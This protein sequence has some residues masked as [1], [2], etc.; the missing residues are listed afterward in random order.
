MHHTRRFSWQMFRKG[1]IFE[2]TEIMGLEKDKKKI[3]VSKTVDQCCP[4]TLTSESS[5]LWKNM[6]TA[7]S[8]NVEG[9]V[10]HTLSFTFTCNLILH[11]KY[12]A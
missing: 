9:N 5:T 3:Q 10:Q 7:D 4:K 12:L 2:A 6:L 1:H 11:S 8:A